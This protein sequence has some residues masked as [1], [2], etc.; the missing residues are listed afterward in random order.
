[1][2]PLYSHR[3]NSRT[4]FFSCLGVFKI[5]SHIIFLE[6][7]SLSAPNFENTLIVAI[8]QR[9]TAE[10]V[11]GGVIKTIDSI[12]N[13]S[14]FSITKLVCGNQVVYAGFWCWGCRI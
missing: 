3:R 10:A 12:I 7:L 4:A 5:W 1:M 2:R 9:G 6:N 11:I 13:H 8:K 14:L